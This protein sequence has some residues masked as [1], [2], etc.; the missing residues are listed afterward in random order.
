[1]RIGVDLDGVCY[2]FAA[3]FRQ[4]LDLKGNKLDFP[5]PTRWEFYEDWGFSLDEFV[6][7]CHAGVDAGV[8]FKHGAP[9]KGTREALRALHRAGHTIHIIT[10]RSFGSAGASKRAT[11]E[12]LQFNQLP[13]DTLTFSNDKTVVPTDFMIDDK[14]QNYDALER[15]GC[16]V[17]LL[18]RP[19]NQ[20][21]GT[22]RRVFSWDEFLAVVA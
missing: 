16:N 15:A 13:Y 8:V 19:W 3:S 9:H 21:E 7:L 2:D 17:Y 20:D 1:M 11:R 18:D 6:G 10:D 14:L 22:R 4:Y 12:W 5:A